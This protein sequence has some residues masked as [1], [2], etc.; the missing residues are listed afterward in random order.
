MKKTLSVIMLSRLEEESLETL[1]FDWEAKEWM[2]DLGRSILQKCSLFKNQPIRVSRL[3]NR[4]PIASIP[5][6]GL[7]REKDAFFNLQ[8]LA[9]LLHRSLI[10]KPVVF[11][12]LLSESMPEWVLEDAGEILEF[13][14]GPLILIEKEMWDRRRAIRDAFPDTG[15][16]V[17]Q[18]ANVTYVV[19]RDL[20][21]KW[22]AQFDQFID[23]F[24]K[25]SPSLQ[26]RDGKEDTR[27][28]KAAILETIVNLPSLSEC[29]T[30]EP[31]S[32]R[33]SLRAEEDAIEASRAAYEDVPEAGESEGM[34]GGRS[35]LLSC[36][37]DRNTYA[38]WN[39]AYQDYEVHNAKALHFVP[40]APVG[41]AVEAMVNQ[42][43]V[44]KG[45]WIVVEREEF[46]EL[47]RGW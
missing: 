18:I 29:P 3:R 5:L 24:R 13:L 45:T 9:D 33:I 8:S 32:I 14:G 44:V 34:L 42:R 41:S 16:Q 6:E 23:K 17:V 40:S 39:K 46:L 28:G 7:D 12:C 15:L 1:F 38:G 21:E 27:D 2:E 10:S 43:V 26:E 37:Y 25:R 20:E 11:Y 30:M 4:K 19:A 35:L 36:N 22:N 47:R 31:E